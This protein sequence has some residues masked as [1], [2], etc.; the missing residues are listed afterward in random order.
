M[1]WSKQPHEMCPATSKSTR[2]PCRLP[3]GF[4]TDHLGSGACKFHGGSSK[5]APKCNSNAV[6]TG[7]YQSILIDQFTPEEQELWDVIDTDQAA[8][9]DEMIRTE[10]M[11]IRQMMQNIN[12]LRD[13]AGED[14]LVLTSETMTT[15]ENM[16]QAIKRED[17]IDRI[18]RIQ[19]GI[20]RVQVAR[21]GLLER[22][23]KMMSGED[24]EKPSSLTINIGQ[25][26]ARV[27]GE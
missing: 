1:V 24:N 8:Q 26:S 10:T 6:R 25:P 5:G 16:S 21:A 14:G 12:K 18:Q 23:A 20:T 27:D 9:L 13:R 19:E 7:E 4:G 17:V 11:R 22:R 15:G 3:A 2:E